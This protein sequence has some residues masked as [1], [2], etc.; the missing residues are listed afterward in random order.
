MFG[1]FGEEVVDPEGRGELG[2]VVGGWRVRWVHVGD[3]GGE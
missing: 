2:L 3:S 1:R